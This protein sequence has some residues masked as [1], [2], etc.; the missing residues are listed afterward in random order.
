MPSELGIY[1]IFFYALSWIFIAI[2]G[3][4]IEMR[5]RIHDHRQHHRQH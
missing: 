3:V 5:D 1:V 2:C 4:V